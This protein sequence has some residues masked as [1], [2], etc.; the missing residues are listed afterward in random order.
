MNILITGGTGL[1]GSAFIR[2]YAQEHFT[3]LTRTPNT[4]KTLLPPGVKFLS[5]L[6]QLENLDAFDAVI[7]LAGEG[8]FNKRWSQQQKTDICASR[9][10]VTDQLVDL[11]AR[12][13]NPPKVFLSGSAIGIY[14]NSSVEHFHE[15]SPIRAQDFGSQL[16]KKWERIA[17][18][19]SNYTRVVLLRTGI[20]L[21][22]QGG[23]LAQMLP[24]FRIGCGGRMG[25]GEQVMSWIHI[26]DQIAAMNYLLHQNSI[27]GAVNL[28]APTPVSNRVF[29]QILARHLKR[30]ALLPLPAKLLKL[31][32]GESACLLL[33]S[34]HVSPTALTQAGFSFSFQ[35]LDEA[36][37]QLTTH[38]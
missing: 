13:I 28:V 31:L 16:C 24:P 33:D 36:L 6:S 15:D 4:A 34:Q 21:S 8:L 7:N 25:N 5:S 20:V 2:G 38:P 26:Q 27:V 1:I 18:K 23:A 14:G 17:L 35:Q 19:A 10:L 30:P 32:F 37:Q 11:F 9:W 12:S 22:T 29:T 3:C